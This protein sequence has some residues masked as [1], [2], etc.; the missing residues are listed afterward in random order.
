MIGVNEYWTHVHQLRV[1]LPHSS[2][3]IVQC[4][5]TGTVAMVLRMSDV[6]RF[7]VTEEWL[8]PVL[9][10]DRNLLLHWWYFPDRYV[11]SA[12]IS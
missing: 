11:D 2:Y 7:H 5:F 1:L 3:P 10:R 9:K 12:V 6:V 4:L 8:R